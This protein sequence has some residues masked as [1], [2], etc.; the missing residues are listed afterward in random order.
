MTETEVLWEEAR[1]FFLY[2]CIGIP[3]DVKADMWIA[4]KQIILDKIGG[5]DE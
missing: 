3:E 1:E 4:Y 2:R 5:K